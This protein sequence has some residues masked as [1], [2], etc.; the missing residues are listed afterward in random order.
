MQQ[1][2]PG[3]G[4][5]EQPSVAG[6]VLAGALL[7]AVLVAASY[8]AVTAGVVVGAGPVALVGILA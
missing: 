4:R 1:F 5:D 3:P 8:P 6:G 2:S 7:G